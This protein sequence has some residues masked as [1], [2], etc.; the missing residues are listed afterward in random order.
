LIGRPREGQKKEKVKQETKG[1]K[2]KDHGQCRAETRHRR[3]R[4]G[5]QWNGE[6]GGT[7]QG[8]QGPAA[9][10]RVPRE[11]HQAAGGECRLGQIA[12]C[13]WQSKR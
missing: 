8:C 9:A 1:K 10:S 11:D 5:R 6:R 7:A 12:G 2:K 13:L 4:N 3:E